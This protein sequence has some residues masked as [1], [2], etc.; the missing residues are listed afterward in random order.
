[1]RASFGQLSR[2]T[3]GD[4][5][6]SGSGDDAIKRLEDVL[7]REFSQLDLDRRV[8]ELRQSEPR[9][10][11]EALAERLASS[12]PA[13]SASVSRLGSRGLL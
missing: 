1:V 2:M 10:P 7:R 6:D 5:F 9:L 4:Y 13:V 3:G 8:L 11:L 12:R